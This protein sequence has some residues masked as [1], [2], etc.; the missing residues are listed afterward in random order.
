[1]T[2][3][4]EQEHPTAPS[5][6]FLGG[7]AAW[8]AAARSAH[9]GPATAAVFLQ[10]NRR[11]WPLVAVTI[12]LQGPQLA[13]GAGH[14]FVYAVYL[15]AMLSPLLLLAPPRF[16]GPVVGAVALLCAPAIAFGS[17]PPLSAV[18]LA[19]A[20][21]LAVLEG[22]RRWA[23]GTLVGLAI[24]GPSAAALVRSSRALTGVPAS[25]VR[26]LAVVLALSLLLELAQMQ[27]G[28]RERHREEARRI[29]AQR[30][31]EAEAERIRIARELHDVLAHSLSQISVQAG[32]GLHLF[33]TQPKR[34][35][36]SLA[37]IKQTS[38]H[39]LEEVRGVLGFL[40]DEGGQGLRTP[41]PGLDRLPGLI[42]S[43]RELGLAVT[44]HDD[45]GADV[46]HSA[47]LAI[48][49]I[50]QES[51]ANVARHAPGAGAQVRLERLGPWC[52]VTVT[53]D[54]AGPAAGHTPG[55]GMVGMRERVQLLR[56][57]FDAGPMGSGGFRVHARIPVGPGDPQ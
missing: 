25:V 42:S 41:G 14:P 43:F 33:D 31:A 2:D 56:G 53:D 52:E 34:A 6:A 24:A 1:M 7:P 45:L 11:G 48:Y 27:R 32:V 28:R 54:G 46:R 5:T 36:E 23:W 12:L 13:F 51:L 9:A 19:V 15:L 30:Q 44:V 17:G 49:R 29:V 26:P 3:G 55:R 21:F 16:A 35:Q 47:Q 10:Q 22:A 8:Y 20:V 57:T 4:R 38:S 39:A 40:R 18:P 37:T 50:V